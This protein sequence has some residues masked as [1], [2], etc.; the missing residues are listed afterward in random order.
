MIFSQKLLLIIK[1]IE[2]LRCRLCA[3][4]PQKWII[5]DEIQY[6][7]EENPEL[8]NYYEVNWNAHYW[9]DRIRQKRV[10]I[11]TLPIELSWPKETEEKVIPACYNYEEDF[12]GLYFIGVS[13]FNPITMI[14]YYFVK[15]G[16]A[17]NIAN[18]LRTYTT[19]NPMI[20]HNNASLPLSL[21]S[22]SNGES[23]CHHFLQRHSIQAPEY[24]KEW[25][26]VDKETYLTFCE[27]FQDPFFFAAVARGEI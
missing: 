17:D 4:N 12:P 19:H 14:P 13:Y 11:D 22:L 10:K 20:F 24:G 18:R 27:R 9:S 3:T 21:Y 5:V 25:F 1:K 8:Q 23:M 7:L 6:Y 26:A 15:I 16:K 2:S